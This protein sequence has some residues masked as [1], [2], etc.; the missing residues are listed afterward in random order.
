[1]SRVMDRVTVIPP[2]IFADSQF[3]LVTL[4]LSPFPRSALQLPSCPIIPAPLLACNSNL[5]GYLS[6]EPGSAQLALSSGYVAGEIRTPSIDS[7]LVDRTHS[8]WVMQGHASNYITN[9]DTTLPLSYTNPLQSFFIGQSSGYP[10][11]SGD[12]SIFGDLD[13][14]FAGPTMNVGPIP[15]F[16]DSISGQVIS[17]DASWSWPSNPPL[18]LPQ[19]PRL[20]DYFVRG[21]ILLPQEQTRTGM[22]V[23][24]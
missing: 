22:V 10:Q 14:S 17:S 16:H 7:P 2:P 11:E 13:N 12:V 21:D 5:V 19:E 3:G 18:P 23:P 15:S 9:H 8:C 1:M 4:T 24:P 6:G 20:A